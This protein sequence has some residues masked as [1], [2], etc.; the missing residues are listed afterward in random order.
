MHPGC[1]IG[2]QKQAKLCRG[3]IATASCLPVTV[4]EFVDWTDPK[5]RDRI[6]R[7]AVI[8]SVDLEI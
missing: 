3:M 1:L 8:A 7:D 2:V 4:P 5:A 6:S